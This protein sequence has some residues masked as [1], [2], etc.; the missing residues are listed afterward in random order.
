[1]HQYLRG[2]AIRFFP[3]ASYE[4]ETLIL[5]PGDRLFVFSDGLI[6]TWEKAEELFSG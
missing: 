3:Q 2:A 1:M 5:Q 6:E 4:T